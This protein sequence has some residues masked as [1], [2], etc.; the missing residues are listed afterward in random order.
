MPILCPWTSCGL[1]N[2]SPPPA[3]CY[4]PRMAVEPIAEG[5]R[6]AYR[7]APDPP[8]EVTVVKVV[9]QSGKANV[10]VQFEDG[11]QAGQITWVTRRSLKVPWEQRDEFVA[12]ERCWEAFRAAG[13]EP[14]RSAREATGIVIEGVVGSQ[15]AWVKAWGVLGVRDMDSLTS[16]VPEVI[17]V[18]TDSIEEDGINYFPWPASLDA[19]K[20]LA[21]MRPASVLEHVELE[22]SLWIEMDRDAGGE[23]EWAKT[24]ISACDLARSWCGEIALGK[25]SEVE[26]LRKD[27]ARLHEL[28][29]KALNVMERLKDDYYTYHAKRLR[30]EAGRAFGPTPEWIKKL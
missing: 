7:K 22:E 10:R 24:M 29:E 11:A 20:A 2:A 8:L 5:E 30:G 4:A 6:W 17:S 25:W 26:N 14:S 21:E 16:L 23:A 15:V 3:R 1:C 18:W 13:R 19:A 28:L 27:N 12:L 9:S